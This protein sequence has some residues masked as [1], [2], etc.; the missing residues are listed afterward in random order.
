M[1]KIVFLWLIFMVS[2]KNTKVNPKKYWK[3]SDGANIGDFISF[4][5]SEL[6]SC[7]IIND[8]I[9][10]NKIA[11]AKLERI[12]NRFVDKVMY[13]EDLKTKKEGRYIEK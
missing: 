6:G 11:V 12:E 13:I 3:Y 1:K 10:K 7:K 9:Y 5:P 2:C 4:N 8:T